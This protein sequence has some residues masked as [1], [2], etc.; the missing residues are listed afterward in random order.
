MAKLLLERSRPHGGNGF[1]PLAS[2]RRGPKKATASAFWLKPQL[3]SRG[4]CGALGGKGQ[5]RENNAYSEGS[6]PPAA[7]RRIGKPSFRIFCL[8]Y[9]FPYSLL[10]FFAFYILSFLSFIFFLKIGQ[11]YFFIINYT[12]FF[13]DSQK[14][15]YLLNIIL[16]KISLS[17]VIQN[18][19]YTY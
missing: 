1:S 12:Y 14:I 13:N 7:Y 8:S 6:V 17:P 9:I 5:G 11:V 3:T 18:Q 2:R 15:I 4:P 16:P 10:Y 19:I